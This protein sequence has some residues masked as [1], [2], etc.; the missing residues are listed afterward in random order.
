M[1]IGQGEAY[2]Y[3]NRVWV[4]IKYIVSPP[5]PLH[6]RVRDHKIKDNSGVKQQFFE[7]VFLLHP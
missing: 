6:H 5:N 2:Q 7:D 3:N 4:T 1:P